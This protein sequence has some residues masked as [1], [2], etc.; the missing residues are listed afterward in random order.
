MRNLT[1]ENQQ[2]LEYHIALIDTLSLCALGKAQSVRTLSPLPHPQ[3]VPCTQQAPV[4]YSS[5]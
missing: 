3:V 1:K 4:H 2:L 5:S